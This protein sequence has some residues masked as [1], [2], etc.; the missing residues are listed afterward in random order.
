MN[1]LQKHRPPF[2]RIRFHSAVSNFGAIP[3]VLG[4]FHWTNF[5]GIFYQA[6]R[7]AHTIFSRLLRY[8][9][10]KELLSVLT[11]HGERVQC[12]VATIPRSS[13][14]GLENKP[15][16]CLALYF[17]KY[18]DLDYGLVY[19]ADL[20]R[21]QVQS[22]YQVYNICFVLNTNYSKCE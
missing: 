14:A 6:D 9:V 15:E 11:A 10:S 2:G 3:W 20:M 16:S 18:A 22:P 21:Y 1:S 4:D 5:V 13:A 12:K 8:A 7:D 19:T 17:G